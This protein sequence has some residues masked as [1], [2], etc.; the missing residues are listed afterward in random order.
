MRTLGLGLCVLLE[1]G[2]LMTYMYIIVSNLFESDVVFGLRGMGEVDPMGGLITTSRVD[3][4]Q[5]V[6]P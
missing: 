4:D 3:K 1:N 2:N 5:V 6:T